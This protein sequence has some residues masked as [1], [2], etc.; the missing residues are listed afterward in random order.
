MSHEARSR[1]LGFDAAVYADPAVCFGN[2]I[3]FTVGDR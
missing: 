2:L 1:H 3:M